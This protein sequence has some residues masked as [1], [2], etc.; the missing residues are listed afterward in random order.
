MK[1]LAE[2]Y[3]MVYF[4]A[5]QPPLLSKRIYIKNGYKYFKSQSTDHDLVLDLRYFYHFLY[6]FSTIDRIPVVA[7]KKNYFK[8]RVK[9][10]K[11]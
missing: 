1:A 4:V 7:L 2:S 9:I 10:S 11:V 3:P 6:A 5:T 8:K